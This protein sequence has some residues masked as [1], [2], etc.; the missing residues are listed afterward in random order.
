ML[1]TAEF[2]VQKNAC[3]AIILKRNIWPCTMMEKGC[4]IGQFGGNK[5]IVLW[6]IL[7]K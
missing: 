6:N 2:F 1:K 7:L 5:G 4:L 3:I